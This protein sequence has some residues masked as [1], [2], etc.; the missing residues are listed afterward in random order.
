SQFGLQVQNI[1]NAL[2]TLVGGEIVGTYRE[3]DDLYD[4]WLRS[5]PGD[6]STQEALEDIS[7]RAGG[8]N[9]VQLANF[10]HFNEARGPNQIDR[11][12]R[13]RK[14]TIVANLAGKALGD[15]MQDVHQ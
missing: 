2:R 14:V 3:N 15:A 5:N 7:L 12:Q 1:A 9:L 11:F 10:V 13:Q 4:V 6:R 8:T